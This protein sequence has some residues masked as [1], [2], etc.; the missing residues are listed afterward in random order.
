MM[1]RS[2]KYITSGSA[3]C[4]V[5]EDFTSH[6]ADQKCFFRHVDNIEYNVM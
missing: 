2:S 3:E 6:W 5:H 4:Y 1:K